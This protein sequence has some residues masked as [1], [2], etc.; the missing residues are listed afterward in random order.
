MKII[1]NS[2][3]RINIQEKIKRALDKKPTL[4][5][6]NS[7][8]L[9]VE[10]VEKLY[11]QNQP[12]KDIRPR[13]E[14]NYKKTKNGKTHKIFS[15][16]RPSSIKIYTNEFP[17]PKT[18]IIETP[19]WSYGEK[20]IDV[21]IIVPL[22]KSHKVIVQ[23]IQ[24]WDLKDDR[25]TK[26]IIYV[27]DACPGKSHLSVIQAWKEK[28]YQV[29]GKI[30]LNANNVG[31]GHACNIGAKHASGKHLMFLNA[32]AIVSPNWIKPLYDI[33]ENNIDIGLVGNLQLKLDGKHVDS[34]G[35]EWSWEKGTFEHIGRHILDGQPIPEVMLFSDLPKK[36]QQSA[37][38]EMV[39]GCCFAVPSDLWNNGLHGFDLNF[40][41]GYWED[42]DLNMRI[43]DL[44]YKIW[45]EPK[46]VI[47]HSPGHSGSGGHPFMD[48]NK[49]YFYNKWVN[50]GKIDRFVKSPRRNPIKIQEIYIK[51]TNAHGDVL[52]AAS[53]TGALKRKYPD[54]KITFATVCPDAIRHNPYIDNIVVPKWSPDQKIATLGGY[55]LVYDMDRTYEFK[56]KQHIMEA[57]AEAYGLKAS[58]SE[59]FI[60]TEEMPNVLFPKKYVVVHGGR[61]AWTGRNWY[62]DKFNEI[63]KRLKEEGHF[64]VEVGINADSDLPS[65]DLRLKGKTNVF[66][67]ASVIKNCQYFFGIDSFPMW[68]AQTFKKSGVCFFGCVDP[69]L[70]LIND[71]IKPVQAEGLSCLGCHHEQ[72]IPCV[73]TNLCKTGTHNCEK[74]ITVNI[75]WDK[76]KE[77]IK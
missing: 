46:S 36:Y 57:Y 38:R 66:Q 31:Y 67:L 33:L 70:R 65:A 7:K 48:F 6:L 43:R 54:A 21:S 23:Q 20:E 1:R 5:H 45:F 58:D 9:T 19:D 30:L 55:D 14:K 53:F 49:Q 24:S 73:G 4:S 69:S 76:I 60:H 8:G 16:N 61:T 42:S 17:V 12:P 29:E 71:R 28:N 35:S 13:I 40:R 74:E 41:V 50:N 18:S 2:N 64:V 32:D 47:Y 62:A 63:T 10:E 25:L 77:T 39:T 51:R 34:A 56:P 52:T 59:L 11:G 22:Y 68:I 44:G 26:E 27:D 15:N 3:A 37:E 75:F 72:S